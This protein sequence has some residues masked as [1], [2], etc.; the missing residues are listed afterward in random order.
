MRDVSV[1]WKAVLVIWPILGVFQPLVASQEQ[2]T[3]I[4]HLFS[5]DPDVRSTTK[6][7]LMQHPDPALLPALLNALP[8]SKGSIRGDLLEILDKYDDPRKLPVFLGLL[9]PFHLDTD[10]SLI[11]QQLARLGGPA[12][13]AVLAGCG[14]PAEGY[15]EWAAG[16]LK[17]METV[18]RASIIAALLSNDDCRREIGRNGLQWAFGEA[19]PN[20]MLNADIRLTSTAATDADER[21]RGAAKKW[22]ESWRGREDS[23]E[24]SGIVEALIMEYQSHAPPETMAKIATMLSDTERPRVT[25]FMRA[26]LHAPN[27]EIQRIA[28][29]YLER[30]APK[31]R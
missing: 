18:G 24:M 20:S 30:F 11:G 23:I 5:S 15:S 22:F 10:S 29:H 4:N 25:R 3:R 27:P 12:A 31:S 28:N 9:K 16:V 13:Q 7:E 17:D 6:K 21:I 8:S 14:D 2:D 26:A 19:D 1:A